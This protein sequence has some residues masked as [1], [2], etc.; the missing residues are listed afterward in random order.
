MLRKSSALPPRCSICSDRGFY[1]LNVE[2]GHP[3]FGQAI[4]CECQKPAY[5]ARRRQASNLAGDLLL[6]TFRGYQV[7]A[8]NREAFT[9]L[10]AFAG[11]PDGWIVLIGEKGTGKTHLM[12]AAA[13][14][15]MEREVWPLYVV[16]PDWLAYLREGLEADRLSEGAEQRMKDAME[17]PVLFLDDLNAERRTDW[18]DEQMFRLVNYRYIHRL[19]TVISGNFTLEELEKRIASRMR[20][21]SL[22]Q[23]IVMAGP[24]QRPTRRRRAKLQAVK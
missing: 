1:R 23:I 12:A 17:A 10:Q 7:R 21:A 15:L 13:N 14:V 5:A 22:S 8:D 11:D 19:P 6:A 16:V 4:R 20:D 9:A 24:D 2:I 3:Q 18:T